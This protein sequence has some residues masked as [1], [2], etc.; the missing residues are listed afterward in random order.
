MATQSHDLQVGRSRRKAG[1]ASHSRGEIPTQRQFLMDFLTEVSTRR[2]QTFP[3][4][5][6]S[7]VQTHSCNLAP[8][9][10]NTRIQPPKRAKPPENSLRNI[11]LF[12]RHR[13]RWLKASE[14]LEQVRIRRGFLGFSAA[15]AN[16]ACRIAKPRC[17]TRALDRGAL[18]K[19]H[20]QMVKRWCSL[21]FTRAVHV[22]L[23]PCTADSVHK[24]RQ[25]T[26]GSCVAFAY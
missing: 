20:S 25:S 18:N 22:R 10:E 26:R 21:P 12:C 17:E 14:C 5:S 2:R 23:V 11:K 9:Q 8:N 24:P 1:K 15:R 6:E 7:K 19:A 3:H 13:I 16:K 4:G